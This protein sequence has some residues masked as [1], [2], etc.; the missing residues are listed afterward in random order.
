MTD[1]KG[2]E[3]EDIH[4]II[5]HTTNVYDITNKKHTFLQL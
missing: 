1:K 4:E 3:G 5:S 2:G